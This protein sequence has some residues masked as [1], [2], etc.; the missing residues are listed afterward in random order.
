MERT[1]TEVTWSRSVEVSPAA[2]ARAF[3]KTPPA[4]ARAANAGAGLRS[5]GGLRDLARLFLTMLV[6]FSLPALVTGRLGESIPTLLIA[7]FAL[8]VPLKLVSGGDED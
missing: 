7:A 8:W 4:A 6:L 3:G 1:D 2:I 5:G